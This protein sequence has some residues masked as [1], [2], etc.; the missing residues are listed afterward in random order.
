MAAPW[1]PPLCIENVL[2]LSCNLKTVMALKARAPEDVP[3][4]NAVPTS[5]LNPGNTDPF[6]KSVP[7]LMLWPD[8]TDDLVTLDSSL[9]R[10]FLLC[11]LCWRLGCSNVSVGINTHRWVRTRVFTLCL[12]LLPVHRFIHCLNLWT[13]D[14]TSCS[15]VPA[16]RRGKCTLAMEAQGRTHP[17]EFSRDNF[18]RN[19][20]ELNNLT[21]IS[22]IHFNWWRHFL[23]TH[24]VAGRLSFRT[25][26]F[27]LF[28]VFLA[29]PDHQLIWY[30][31]ESRQYQA[32]IPGFKHKS[33]SIMINF[34]RFWV[35]LA[36][37]IDATF[38]L[39]QRLDKV[40]ILHLLTIW[41]LKVFIGLLVELIFR[42]DKI[43]LKLY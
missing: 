38:R 7:S 32:W 15:C 12:L 22:S 41:S 27:L 5:F 17:Q 43:K 11:G 37:L 16:L 36:T 18:W 35:V 34:I 24:V 39:L 42:F 21:L 8:V 20:T 23:P 1:F 3:T 6:Y 10:Y 2:L 4:H 40:L 25:S 26:T 19:T 13:C 30:L 9:T 28:I 33:I 31:V 29:L 14:V